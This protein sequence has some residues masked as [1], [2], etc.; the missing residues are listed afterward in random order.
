MVR[1][2][3]SLLRDA[4]LPQGAQLEK[5]PVGA[6]SEYRLIKDFT[7]PV[8]LTVAQAGGFRPLWFRGAAT[9][10]SAPA[11]MFHVKH[12]PDRIPDKKAPGRGLFIQ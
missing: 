1:Q 9:T 4:A 3:N 2:S 7:V 12:L 8:F 10:R 11:A 5:A 6:F